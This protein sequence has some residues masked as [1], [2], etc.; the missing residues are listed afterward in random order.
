MGSSTQLHLNSFTRF[1]QNKN[2]VIS[3]DSFALKEA[4]KAACNIFKEYKTFALCIVFVLLD[5]P[6][7]ICND[8]K[9]DFCLFFHF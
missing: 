1:D 5:L 7:Q 2:F 3:Y 8:P 6:I 9:F 4:W